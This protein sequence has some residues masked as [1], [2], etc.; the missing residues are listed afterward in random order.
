MA[1][2]RPKKALV[3]TSLLL[4]TTALQLIAAMIAP[5]YA[6]ELTD[7][8][9]NLG[10][11]VLESGNIGAGDGFQPQQSSA[12]T[13]IDAP[14]DELPLSIDV[15]TP[16]VI[17]ATN[18]GR[19]QDVVTATTGA[20]I[21][22]QFGGLQN[23]FILRGFDANVSENGGPSA[24]SE[25]RQHDSANVE[26]IEVL[27]GP[28]SALFGFGPPGG[29]VNVISKT[30]QNEQFARFE[31]EL[32]SLASLRQEFD[33]NSPLTADGNV[34]ARLTG[35]IEGS[36]SFRFSDFSDETF[37]E[38]RVSLSPSIL[39]EPTD[40]LSVLLLGDFTQDT[41][42]FD[43]G[44]AIGLDGEPV[45]DIDDFLGDPQFDDFISENISGSVEVIY[46]LNSDW[47]VTGTL[48]GNQNKRDGYAVEAEA[49]G[50]RG[51]LDQSLRWI[52]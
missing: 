33:L 28:S 40:D 24:F 46:D 19:V 34:T 12:L 44:I 14:L 10:T 6:Q 17:E 29:V 32:S 27:S 37:T 38:D 35:A 7:E 26:R 20:A 52:A 49:R 15:I 3:K 48:A 23:S 36:D 18:A 4:S 22:N 9:V 16:D 47:F 13:G 41:R 42:I 1:T 31:T 25:N 39:F 2:I 50:G 11:V 21:G 30:P 45:S 5:A 43:R 8:P 51:N